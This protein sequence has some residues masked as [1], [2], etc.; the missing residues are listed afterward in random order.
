MMAAALPVAMTASCLRAGSL[1]A[2]F[3]GTTLGKVVLVLRDLMADVT[4]MPGMVLK[5][6]GLSPS[7]HC[8]DLHG[9]VLWS[10]PILRFLDVVSDRDRLRETAEHATPD[11]Y[12]TVLTGMLHRPLRAALDAL[13]EVLGR[14][15]EADSVEQ[16]ARMI[17]TDLPPSRRGLTGDLAA[18]RDEPVR[19]RPDLWLVETGWDNLTETATAFDER[20]RCLRA[21]MPGLSPSGIRSEMRRIAA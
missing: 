2:G 5:R 20:V 17:L 1:S 4:A 9:L 8:F 10:R 19:F 3:D 12:R 7:L 16:V 14:P 11:N 6:H 15:P 13:R 18:F 21:A